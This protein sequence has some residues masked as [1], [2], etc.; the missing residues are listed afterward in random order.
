MLVQLH[1]N[2]ESG[3]YIIKNLESGYITYSKD[4]DCRKHGQLGACGESN[5]DCYHIT[6][7]SGCVDPFAC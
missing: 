4:K 5:M 2:N 3:E 1:L 6:N 7:T